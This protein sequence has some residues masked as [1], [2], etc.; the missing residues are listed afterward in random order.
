MIV[1]CD[2]T[3][4]CV[5]GGHSHFYACEHTKSSPFANPRL[6]A[7]ISS[8]LYQHFKYT[9][10]FTPSGPLALLVGSHKG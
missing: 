1:S 9:Y 5:R 8:F 6:P 4:F 3:L 10:D 7:T 2:R